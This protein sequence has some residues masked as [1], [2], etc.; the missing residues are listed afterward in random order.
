PP[1]RSS[2]LEDPA[3]ALAGVDTTTGRV[4][5][6]APDV[7]ANYIWK[8]PRGHVQFSGF[9]GVSR[10][11]PA[12]GATDKVALWGVNLSTKLTTWG[13]DNTILQLTYGDGVGRY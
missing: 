13:D 7:T 12:V 10:F 1:R 4:E 5:E 8:M 9:G 2:D 11:N 3:S 6:V